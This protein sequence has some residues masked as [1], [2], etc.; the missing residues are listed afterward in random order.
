M[1]LLGFLIQKMETVNQK[2]ESWR[3]RLNQTTVK[4]NNASKNGNGGS[5]Q[6][7][8]N[9]TNPTQVTETSVELEYEP[10]LEPEPD[11]DM[12]KWNGPYTIDDFFI[13]DDGQDMV[14]PMTKLYPYQRGGVS[15]MDGDY[16]DF[17][18]GRIVLA[19]AMG[20]GKTIQA[21]TWVNNARIER[22]PCLV[23]CPAGLKINWEREAAKHIGMRA[24]ILE[25]KKVPKLGF[26]QFHKLY[27]INYDILAAWVDYLVEL[28][29]KTIIFDEGHYLKNRM[30][31]RTKAAIA[32]C[33]KAGIKFRF[34]LTGTPIM[35][36][37]AE[38]WQL[39]NI[40]RP[41]LF[42]NFFKFAFKYCK[43]EKKFWG[44][45][46]NGAQNLDHLHRKLK[47]TCMI[48]RLK[49][50][51]L[52]QLPKQSRIIVPMEISD[53]KQYEHA[54]RDLIGWIRSFDPAQATRAARAEGLIKSGY[55]KRLTGRLKLPSVLEWIDNFLEN[56]DG[57]IIVF[58]DQHVVV[59]AIHERYKHMSVLL[60][61]K[62]SKSQRQ[63]VKDQFDNHKQTRI[64]VANMQA[65]G[66]GWNGIV[67]QTILFAELHWVPAMHSQAAA[68]IDRIGQTKRTEAYY[69]IGRDTIEEKLMEM[70]QKKQR[71]ANNAIDGFGQGENMDLHS[72]FLLSI[73]KGVR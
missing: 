38:I 37:P 21:L 45:T 65:G 24:E 29:I 72:E 53:R 16:R 36:R 49:S 55:L 57:K 69:A 41:D 43:P 73:M 35:N 3:K 48:R 8:T 58:G 5:W 23:V 39:L 1:G 68:R 19:D 40:V 52:K 56:D 30:A 33:K 60:Y 54:F 6:Q 7:P 50:Q 22:C 10:P 26:G 67:A 59:E 47:R 18:E 9:P 63:R 61:G 64:M 14:N 11:W 4:T 31:K 70:I 51:V 66:V 27:I 13:N 17:E 28:G 15:I 34:I 12:F 71:D 62:T 42:P 32:L 44:W 46:Y 20:L 2:L 25:G